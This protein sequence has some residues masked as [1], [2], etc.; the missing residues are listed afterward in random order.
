MSFISADMQKLEK[1]VHQRK[2]TNSATGQGA[3]EQTNR[4]CNKERLRLFIHGHDEGNQGNEETG[5]ERGTAEL[6]WD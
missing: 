2:Q 4:C 5:G 1:K 3:D 6:N